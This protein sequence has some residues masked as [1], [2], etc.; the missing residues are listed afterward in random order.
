MIAQVRRLGM[1]RL[2]LA[3]PVYEKESLLIRKMEPPCALLCF[4]VACNHILLSDQ[5]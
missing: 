4:Q 5:R 1:P 3:C 2:S